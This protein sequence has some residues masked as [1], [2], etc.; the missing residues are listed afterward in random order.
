MDV[1][2]KEAAEHRHEKQEL[3]NMI[4]KLKQKSGK[5]DDQ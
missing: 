2:I 1:F 3:L 5:L 4:E